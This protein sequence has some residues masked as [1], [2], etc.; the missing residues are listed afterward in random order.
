MEGMRDTYKISVGK[1]EVKRPFGKYGRRW[2]DNIRMDLTFLEKQGGK[3]GSGFMWLR[4]GI[5]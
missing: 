4:M 1:P 3:L 5:M 2:E